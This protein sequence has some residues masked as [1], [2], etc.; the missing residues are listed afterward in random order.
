MTTNPIAFAAPRRDAEPIMV[1]MATS[2]VAD[3]KIRV[4][5]NRGDKLPQGWIIDRHGQPSTDPGDYLNEPRGAILPLGGVAAHKGYCLSFIVELLGG[6]LSGQGCAAG[7]RSLKS[8]GVMLNVYDISFFSDLDDY[9]DEV[10]SLIGHVRSSRVDPAIGEI[11]IPGEP[12]LRTA[13]ARRAHGIEL[14]VTT[15]SRICE[16]GEHLGLD[17]SHWRAM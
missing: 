2:V 15:W 16:A 10:E 12:E 4:A 8:N 6:T 14:D 5:H 17:T 1:D 9:Y 3:G 11:L 13:Q 7:E